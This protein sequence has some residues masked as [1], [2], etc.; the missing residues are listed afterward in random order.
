M[1]GIKMEDKIEERY[2]RFLKKSVED[3]IGW[4]QAIHPTFMSGDDDV[5]K[6]LSWSPSYFDSSAFKESVYYEEGDENAPFFSE[7]FLY[8]LLGK[9][10]ART[11][12]ALIE[13][14]LKTKGAFL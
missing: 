9:D 2:L 12:S 5:K 13:K 4:I 14:A 8:S 11:L 10:D 6:L 3:T 7:A 1:R